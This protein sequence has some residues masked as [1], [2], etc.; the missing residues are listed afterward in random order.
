MS[1]IL[2]R[3]L[4]HIYKALAYVVHCKS[5]EIIMPKMCIAVTVTTCFKLFMP[6]I[7]TNSCKHFFIFCLI[8]VWNS[9]SD[10]CFN[11]DIVNFLSA[12]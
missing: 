10:S 5:Y 9:L 4:F 8:T 2:L 12:N 3:R 7:K 1:V 6:I 11:T